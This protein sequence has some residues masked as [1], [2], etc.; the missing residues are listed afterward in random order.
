[1][2]P[3]TPAE[4]AAEIEIKLQR[5]E[6]F[7]RERQ[8]A[9]VSLTLANNFSWIT[10]GLADNQVAH[11]HDV[12]AAS[13]II[14]RDGLKFVVAAHSEIPRLMDQALTKLG[15]TPFETPWYK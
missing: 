6:N 14:T 12:G 8:F 11:S 15:Y 4:F 13:A 2:L 3:C 1:M 9:A 7:M 5:L 10:A